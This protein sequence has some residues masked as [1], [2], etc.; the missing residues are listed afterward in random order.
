MPSSS[1]TLTDAP[2][3]EIFVLM[4]PG[5]IPL[6]NWNVT[7]IFPTRSRNFCN[8][9]KYRVFKHTPKTKCWIVG[10]ATI[11]S[12]HC[13]IDHVNITLLSLHLTVKFHLSF[14]GSTPLSYRLQSNSSGL[15]PIKT[16]L[17]TITPIL[18]I[19]IK[20][21]GGQCKNHHFVNVVP[22]ICIAKFTME[23][24][25]LAHLGIIPRHES[26]EPFLIVMDP[27]ILAWWQPPARLQPF[28]ESNMC[29]HLCF[30]E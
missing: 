5:I 2:V 16:K 13:C 12:S 19:T 4:W 14:F 6:L 21:T 30:R 22:M 1:L 17:D 27:Q 10:G 25:S 20:G 15:A 28:G 23:P 9:R 8:T 7:L 11:R 24:K 3:F 29:C 18:N 26:V